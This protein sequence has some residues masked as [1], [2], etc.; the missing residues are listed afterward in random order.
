MISIEVGLG[1]GTALGCCV[2]GT[3]AGDVKVD[4]KDDVLVIGDGDVTDGVAAAAG[5]TGDV[6]V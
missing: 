3:T 4:V 6:A 2:E 1:F 5:V